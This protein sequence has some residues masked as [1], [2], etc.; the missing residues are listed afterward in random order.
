MVRSLIKEKF[1]EAHM[2]V[3]GP[4]HTG[5]NRFRDFGYYPKKQLISK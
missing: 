4:D 2:E 3:G 1:D 5:H